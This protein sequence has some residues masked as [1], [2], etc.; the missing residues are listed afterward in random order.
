MT[1]A[2]LAVLSLLGEQPRHG[3]EIESILEERGMRDWTEIGFSSIYYILKKLEGEGWIESRLEPAA[4]KGPA[5]RVFTITPAG[6]G[7]WLEGILSALSEPRRCYS[8]FQLGLAYLPAL[9]QEQ[10]LQ[11]LRRYREALAGQRR[12][13]QGRYEASRERMPPHV[14]SMFDLSLTLIESE[15]GWLEAFIR[16]METSDERKD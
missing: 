14:N 4:G 2:E 1:N 13:V 7:A 9:P 15:L 3:Y 5:R 11:A 16:K 6:R 12:Y 8:P 10:A